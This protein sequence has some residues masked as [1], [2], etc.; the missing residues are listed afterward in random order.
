MPRPCS[1]CRHPRLPEITVDLAN[2]IIDKQV[3]ARYGL[4]TSAVQRHRQHLGAPTAA[5]VTAAKSQAFTALAALPSAE[6]AGAALASI[7]TRIDAIATRAESEG[8]LAVAL[9]G[10]KELRATVVGQAQVAGHIGAGA[11]VQVNTQLNLDLAGAVKELIAA[12]KPSPDPVIPAE[13]AAHFDGGGK[14]DP[15]ALARLEAIVDAK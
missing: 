13:L 2:G 15:Q 3:A 11:R 12:I 10:L 1:L 7:A 5:Q 4:S 14:P 6:E 8:S 9:M